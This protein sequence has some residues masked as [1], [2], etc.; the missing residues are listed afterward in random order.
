MMPA[1]RASLAS[2]GGKMLPACQCGSFL[3]GGSRSSQNVSMFAKCFDFARCL[4]CVLLRLWQ[5]TRQAWWRK[6]SQVS[7]QK[8]FSRSW[9]VFRD[10][11]RG[12]HNLILCVQI[13]LKVLASTF[14]YPNEVERIGPMDMLLP[15]V[16]LRA[17]LERNRICS[18]RNYHLQ[19]ANLFQWHICVHEWVNVRNIVT[20]PR[21][22]NCKHLAF[23]PRYPILKS[24][25]FLCC[26]SC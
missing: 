10:I 2:L 18:T 19:S 14:V 8:M 5:P 3:G 20:M 9:K 7:P 25:V 23:S 17:V 26:P 4:D 11:Q 13:S 21:H 12:K 24:C 22:W 1:S 16:L 15:L 6:E